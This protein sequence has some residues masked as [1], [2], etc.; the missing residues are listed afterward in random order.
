MGDFVEVNILNICSFVPPEQSRQIK[1]LEYWRRNAHLK[2]LHG[3]LQMII[4]RPEEA[5]CLEQNQPCVN[6]SY[7]G[8]AYCRSGC[9]LKLDAKKLSYILLA[10]ERCV[11]GV[12]WPPQGS[13]KPG[14]WCDVSAQPLPK[15]IR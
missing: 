13:G 5:H 12:W 1:A 4:H 14:S 3:G 8:L 6:Y 15:P 11:V 10:F 9:L 7:C 2:A